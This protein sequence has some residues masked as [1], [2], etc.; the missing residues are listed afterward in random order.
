MPYFFT[1]GIIYMMLDKRSID[2]L[3]SLDDAKLTAVIKKLASDAGI[4][5]ST[6]NVGRDQ[7]VGIRKALSSATDI[8][9]ARAGELLKSF[10]K[11][12]NGH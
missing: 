2:M 6:I 12:K 11:E 9:I 10:Q 3:L 7:L 8:D 4:D 1:K 5:P